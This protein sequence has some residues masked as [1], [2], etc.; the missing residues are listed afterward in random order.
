[1][2]QRAFG[3]HFGPDQFDEIGIETPKERAVAERW[4]VCGACRRYRRPGKSERGDGEP[5]EES[6]AHA[7]SLSV[8]VS[9]R[10]SSRRPRMTPLAR[11]PSRQLTM[12]LAVSFAYRRSG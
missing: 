5:R 4:G 9:S 1:D 7:L 11:D 2:R 12:P 10:L 8:D 6:N 3:R